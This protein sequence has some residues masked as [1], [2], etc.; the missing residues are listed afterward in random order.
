M[1]FHWPCRLHLGTSDCQV[2]QKHY[3]LHLHHPLDW[4]N[5]CQILGKHRMMSGDLLPLIW[6][7]KDEIISNRLIN[8]ESIIFRIYIL[9]E[10]FQKKL[11]VE[12][13]PSFARESKLPTTPLGLRLA[14]VVD[15]LCPVP[16]PIVPEYEAELMIVPVEW[17]LLCCAMILRL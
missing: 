13:S 4:L 2:F 14:V 6:E 15:G 5:V 8:F 7:R 1:F 17:F 16:P 12:F 10:V 9:S 11:P 3:D